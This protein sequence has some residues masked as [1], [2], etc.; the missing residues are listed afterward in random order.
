MKVKLP[1]TGLAVRSC[2]ATALLSAV[3]AVLLAGCA[4]KNVE[5]EKA[6]QVQLGEFSSADENTALGVARIFAGAFEKSLVSGE[7]KHLV[8]YLPG[9]AKFTAADF[10]RMR[11][12]LHQL[13]G[14]PQKLTY[15]TSLNQGKLRDMLWKIT[16][17][18]Q[19]TSGG[20]EEV[21]EILLCVRIFREP[22]KQPAIAGFS[23]KR[24]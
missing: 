20:T 24:F 17:V 3:F 13:Y 19:S 10:N 22:G 12:A 16:F 5:A 7:F 2:A 11:G 4:G 18:R 15:A 23:L 1:L 6:P 9:A 8:P 14:T 21:R